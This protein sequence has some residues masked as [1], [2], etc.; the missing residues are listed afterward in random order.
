VR[1]ACNWRIQLCW[2]VFMCNQK[3][4]SSQLN[5]LCV[6]KKETKIR[7]QIQKQNPAWLR[8]YTPD[9]SPWISPV[10]GSES[11]VGRTCETWD[12]SR[13][14]RSEW[15]M[16][17][18]SGETTEEDDVTGVGRGESEI[19]R[20]EWGWWR[21]AGSWFQRHKVKLTERNDQLFVMRTI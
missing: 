19:E 17:D 1:R 21:E 4:T 20:L 3:L 8:S 6:T 14:W 12:L 7:K 16:D 2:V 5:L 9:E 13:L 10:R 15:V 11:P 18:E